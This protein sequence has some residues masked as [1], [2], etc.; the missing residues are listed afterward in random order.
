MNPTYGAS[1]APLQVWRAFDGL[2][3]LRGLHLRRERKY[4]RLCSL[5]QQLEVMQRRRV[6]VL[7]SHEEPLLDHAELVRA[8]AE[9]VVERVH[10]VAAAQVLIDHL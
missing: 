10:L 2:T 3:D 9:L 7:Q 5:E 1:H 8:L 4:L 6:A